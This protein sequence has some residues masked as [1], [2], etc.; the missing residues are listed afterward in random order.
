MKALLV[1][2]GRLV[3]HLARHLLAAGDEVALIVRSRRDAEE[4]ARVLKVLVV[5]GDGSDPR[6]QED[7]GA[8]GAE[9]VVAVTPRDADNI[10]TCLVA[11]RRFEVPRT[12]ALLH[13]PQNEE[14]LEP[15]GITRALNQTLLWAGLIQQEVSSREVTNLVPLKP[16]RVNAIEV[17]IGEGNPWADRE[18]REVPLPEGSLVA[19]LSRR[20]EHLVPRGGTVLRAGDRAMVVCTPE[21]Q[22]A[23]VRVLTEG[24]DR[25]A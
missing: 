12:Y 7:A 22:G 6:R 13:D 21:V 20:D 1:G 5:H 15:L 17:R 18:L 24:V 11:R 3:L 14:L 4:F 2:G 8:A 23:V 25:G 19:M 16:G 10:I 9:V